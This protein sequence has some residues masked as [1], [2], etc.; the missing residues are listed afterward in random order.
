MLNSLLIKN[1]AIIESVELLFHSELNII[2]GETGAGKSILIGALQL[3][4]G[5]RADLSVLFDKDKKCIVEGIFNIQ[6]YDL[7][8]LFAFHDIDYSDELIIRREISPTSKSRAFIND[9]PV[10]LNI[11]S[12]IARELV[13]LHQQFDTLDIY[14]ANKQI[15]LLDIIAG[16]R[17]KLRSYQNSFKAYSDCSKELTEARLLYN[18]GKKEIDYLKFQLDELQTLQLQSGEQEEAENLLKAL[19]N[20]ED[21]QETSHKLIMRIHDSEESISNE[22]HEF[23]R[24]LT[25]LGK[26]N[27]AYN[28]IEIRLTTLIN[29]LADI[30]SEL[31]DMINAV[32]NK[33]YNAEELKDRLDTIYRLQ[34]KH[35]VQTIDELMVLTEALTKKYS[36][37]INGEEHLEK[38]AL[39]LN[40]LEKV[41]DKK[42]ADLSK[43]R[44][45]TKNS[46]EKEIQKLLAE[47]AMED[48]RIELSLKETTLGP[49]GKDDIQ[50]LFSANGGVKPIPI[51]KVA[52]G[53]E[54]SRLNLCL[55]ALVADKINLPTL[56]FDE[57]D[58][59]IS[60]EV[61]QR[62][63]QIIDELSTSHQIIVITHSP[64]VA[65]KGDHHLFVFKQRHNKMTHTHIKQLDVDERQ[66][67]IAKMLSGEPPSEAALENA[68]E[69]LSRTR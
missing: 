20:A 29:E 63:G 14:N 46:F 65:S 5:K 68:K 62:M 48:A 13:D 19:E 69:L 25:R 56:V 31:K 21:I 42:A 3:I 8:K 17:D 45:K 30:T 38:L 11:L 61:A 36:N 41:A 44:K 12:E 66:L 54:L 58:T 43:S 10:V 26:Y 60:G 34:N 16:N 33:S 55:K 9:T 32:D 2:T 1:Y 6:Q 67:E 40:K 18:E 47:L 57:I 64:Q 50:L 59:G 35:Q 23:V 37:Y 28:P 4:L 24:E 51:K 52:S 15:E 27:D 39:E 49:L 22:I 53:G 7:E